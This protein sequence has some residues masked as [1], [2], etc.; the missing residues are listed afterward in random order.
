MARKDGLESA[1][2]D[3]RLIDETIDVLREFHE[4]V[5]MLFKDLSNWFEQIL[6]EGLFII[7]SFF[8]SWVDIS[9][10]SFVE[11]LNLLA[12]IIESFWNI[13]IEKSLDVLEDMDCLFM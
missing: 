11:I 4:T 13:R 12:S 7:K 3:A 8:V 2:L 5:G 6:N 9:L 10:H 1:A